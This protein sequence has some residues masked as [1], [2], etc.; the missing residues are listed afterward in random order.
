V[1]NLVFVRYERYIVSSEWTSADVCLKKSLGS[2]MLQT[3]NIM[4]W[5]MV[6]IA[7]PN[8]VTVKTQIVLCSTR[9]RVPTSTYKTQLA[10]MWSISCNIE[11]LV[12]QQ[13]QQKIQWSMFQ[14]RSLYHSQQAITA[15]RQSAPHDDLI[16]RIRATAAWKQN[17]SEA[18]GR[19][20]ACDL[21][22]CLRQG[23]VKKRTS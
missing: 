23:K 18:L 4:S 11:H 6:S 19:C 20:V 21:K 3:L 7:I 10:S 22:R 16:M 5:C 9:L 2:Y 12:H 8:V 17:W 15:K 13:S 14:Q 1:R